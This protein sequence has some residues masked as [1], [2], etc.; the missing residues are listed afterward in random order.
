VFAPKGKVKNE[1]PERKK[2]AGASE[3][4]REIRQVERECLAA[5]LARDVETLKKM[6]CDEFVV[7]SPLNR[8]NRGE[9]VLELLSRGIISHSTVDARIELI[10]RHGPLV[11]VMGQE[12]VT[13]SPG[14][15]SYERRFTN[16]WRERSGDEAGAGPWKLLARHANRIAAAG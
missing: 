14:S 7:N 10:E 1:N 2:N 3:W 13:D 15:A 11:F 6:W 4:E 8:I 9:Q 16:I 12:T 5:F